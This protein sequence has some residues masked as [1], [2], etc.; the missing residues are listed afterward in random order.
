MSQLVCTGLFKVSCSCVGAKPTQLSAFA[1]AG[2]F[3]VQR[4]TAQ[5]RK[6]QK[7]APVSSPSEQLDAQ[8]EPEDMQRSTSADGTG[9]EGAKLQT[10]GEHDGIA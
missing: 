6:A 8:T 7:H 10:A 4:R 2:G 3:L 9:A 1:E 5:R